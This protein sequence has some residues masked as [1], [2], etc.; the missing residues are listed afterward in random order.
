MI[1]G[2]CNF[3]SSAWVISIAFM[4]KGHVT[5]EGIAK[6]FLRILSP[7]VRFRSIACDDGTWQ[8]TEIDE[9]YHFVRDAG[10][11]FGHVSQTLSLLMMQPLDRTRPLW[12]CHVVPSAGLAVLRVHHC[13]CDG[14]NLVRVLG[15]LSVGNTTVSAAAAA[16]LNKQQEEAGAHPSKNLMELVS[17]KITGTV[18]GV[19]GG[20]VTTGEFL[21]HCVKASMVG[22]NDSLDTS[23]P[24][25]TRSESER[26][27]GEFGGPR[28]VIMVPPHSLDY[29]KA[30]KKA[31]A[32]KFDTPVALTT[33]LVAVFTGAMRRYIEARSP[34]SLE[35]VKMRV[36]IPVP[37][38]VSKKDKTPDGKPNPDGLYNSFVAIMADMAL[39][40][41]T[42]VER[43][44][45]THKLLS[46]INWPM[47]AVCSD[48][49]A[50]TFLP[51]MP[52]KMRQEKVLNFIAQHT[53][54]LSNVPG[55]D[56]H[57]FVG[58]CRV[59]S[60][61]VMLPTINPQVTILSYDGH[62]HLAA[63]VDPEVVAD[64][65]LLARMYLLELAEMG[66]A[67]GVY[68]DPITNAEIVGAPGGARA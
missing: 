42:P 63:I 13:V 43:L 31:Y 1:P 37:V 32:T 5:V 64:P 36:S 9:S 7:F 41:P 4:L 33:V 45:K 20:V 17:K 67:L 46:Q 57:G 58:G 38:P 3:P 10:A 35:G 47:M 48:F 39:D 15:G 28:K 22:M 44:D 16:K 49:M 27:K 24:N 18:K 40:Q 34:Q 54:G 2:E 60:I 29:V 6:D 23:I 26:A 66:K 52:D 25:L 68:R 62:L 21:N 19:V 59:E 55:P 56:T 51:L 11:G 53:L 30:I 12:R 61:Y 50:S 14:L 65:E 8:P